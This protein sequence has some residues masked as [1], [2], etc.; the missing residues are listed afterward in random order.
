M[1]NQIPTFKLILLGDG[2]IGKTAFVKKHVIGE[3][4]RN[5]V[6]TIGAEVHPLKFYTTRGE[7]IFDVWDTA[8]LD[9]FAGIRAAYSNQAHCA[10]IMFDVTAKMTYIHVLNWYKDLADDCKNIPIVLCGNKV[11]SRDRKVKDIA[12]HRNNNLKYYDIS[13][14]NN[15]NFEKPFLWLARKLVGDGNLEFIVM[16]A[17]MPPDIKLDANLA[18]QYER[19]LQAAVN[20]AIPDDYD[21]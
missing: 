17:I 8:G 13:A 6:P 11:D 20:N 5:Y 1:A 4:K 12:F 10:I 16:P 7:I 21:L 2:G 3:F 14:K 19:R 18:A 15:H 9:K